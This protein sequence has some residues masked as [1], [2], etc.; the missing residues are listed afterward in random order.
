MFFFIQPS[1]IIQP[2]SVIK[3]DFSDLQQTEADSFDSDESVPMYRLVLAGDA[4][5]GKSSFLLRLSLN[6]FRG[7]MQTTLGKHF[8]VLVFCC[9][10]LLSYCIINYANIEMNT[11]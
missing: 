2:F 5:S 3:S 8:N 7:D 4:G 9:V 6:E 10:I 11:R 1:I